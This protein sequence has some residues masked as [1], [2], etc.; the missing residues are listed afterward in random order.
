MSEGKR[1]AVYQTDLAQTPLPDILLTV[2][3]YKVPGVIECRRGYDVKKIY[4]DRGLIIFA[5]TNVIRESLGD[6]LYEAGRITRE[7]YDQSIEVLRTTGKRHGETLVEMGLL[8]ADELV[9]A[10]QDQIETIVFSLFTWD[11]GAVTFT[12]GR[13]KSLEF[14]KVELS[15]PEAILRGVPLMSD[16]RSLLARMGTR[17]TLFERRPIPSDAPTLPTTYQRLYDLADGKHPLPELV[18]APPLSQSEN[19]RLLYGLFVLQWIA[20]KQPL[21]VKVRVAQK[22]DPSSA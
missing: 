5:T 13:D 17:T 22:E 11:S 8:E 4:L 7:E 12:P 19:V 6:K 1:I 20:V 15:V 2:H 18:A 3:R 21:Q 14:V 9:E 16:A 10:V